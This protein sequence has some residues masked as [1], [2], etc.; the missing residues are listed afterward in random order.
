[1]HDEYLSPSYFFS[2]LCTF[3][4]LF[5]FSSLLLFS[6][7]DPLRFLFTGTQFFSGE[8]S[9]PDEIRTYRVSHLKRP[10]QLS[11]NLFVMEKKEYKSSKWNLLRFFVMQR[12]ERNTQFYRIKFTSE[13]G[14]LS[15]DSWLS[16]DAIARCFP[17]HFS[18]TISLQHVYN[19]T[20]R[21]KR[22]TLYNT[23]AYVRYKWRNLR[24]EKFCLSGWS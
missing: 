20:E 23:Y 15:Q 3:P 11:P 21:F 9:L 1:M 17:R 14:H 22:D 4:G 5:L 16:S 7:V 13:L 19:C 6:L 18:V 10:A 8:I 24:K 12:A 2:F